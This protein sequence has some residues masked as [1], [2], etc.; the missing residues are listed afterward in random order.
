MYKILTTLL[1]GF[2]LFLGM[3]TRT[4]DIK[5]KNSSQIVYLDIVFT[6]IEK[7]EKQTGYDEIYIQQLEDYLQ[8][9]EILGSLYQV[10]SGNLVGEMK[11]N[12][13]IFHFEGKNLK[14][15]FQI[16]TI[17]Q[18]H[19]IHLSDKIQL[20]AFEG[21]I[22]YDGSHYTYKQQNMNLNITILILFMMICMVF[23]SSL[24]FFY[25]KYPKEKIKTFLV[26]EIIVRL[27]YSIMVLNSLFL[28]GSGLCLF[29][30]LFIGILLWI[31]NLLVIFFTYKKISRKQNL[32]LTLSSNGFSIIIAFLFSWL[33]ALF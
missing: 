15:P 26:S 12:D 6:D 5:V 31:I 27:F 17:D 16:I 24:F 13:L 20:K 19:E 23:V 21:I 11:K 18:N 1:L 25:L 7:N 32:I 10:V 22:Y 14:R 3:N 9:G 33:I 28:D 29:T 30:I 2:S 8:D 4:L